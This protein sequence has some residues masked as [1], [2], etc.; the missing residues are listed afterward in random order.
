MTVILV[1][2]NVDNLNLFNGPDIYPLS[3]SLD[4]LGPKIGLSHPLILGNIL[5][6]SA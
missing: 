2:D 3:M 1:V 6:L 4:P 5:Y